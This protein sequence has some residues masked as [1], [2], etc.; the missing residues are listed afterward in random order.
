[1][2]SFNATFC[3]FV[4]SA[5]FLVTKFHRYKV[6][7]KDVILKRGMG[8]AVRGR[9]GDARGDARGKLFGKIYD[10][11]VK[12]IKNLMTFLMNDAK[13]VF[14]MICYM[15]ILKLNLSKNPRFR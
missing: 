8:D 14:D 10:E 1:M 11:R 13:P 4:T 15:H 12:N 3:G 2:M 6:F 5:H 7:I 9:E